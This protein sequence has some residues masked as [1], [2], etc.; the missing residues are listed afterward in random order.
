L[1]IRVFQ[2]LIVVHESHEVPPAQRQSTAAPEHQ[3]TRKTHEKHRKFATTMVWE[4]ETIS[5]HRYRRNKSK[6]FA[7]TMVT[8]PQTTNI[9]P[10]EIPNETKI[11]TQQEETYLTRRT[12]HR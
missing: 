5:N 6:T 2:K 8:P 10:A 1:F 7:P 9:F 3:N 11:K 4:F 12:K